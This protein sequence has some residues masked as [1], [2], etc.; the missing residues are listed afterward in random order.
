LYV[1]ESKFLPLVA[2]GFGTQ[3]AGTFRGSRLRALSLSCAGAQ[4]DFPNQQSQWVA[5]VLV[6]FEESIVV[7][8]A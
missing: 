5:E 4:L 8:W 7:G 1:A 2:L 3:E 6:Q